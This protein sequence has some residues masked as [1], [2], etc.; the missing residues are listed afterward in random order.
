MYGHNL[1]NSAIQC[2][3]NLSRIMTLSACKE[4]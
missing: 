1:G 4:E 2:D 3:C